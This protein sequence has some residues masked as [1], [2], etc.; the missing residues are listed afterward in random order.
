MSFPR[1]PTYMGSGIEWLGD[2]PVHWKVLPIRRS[3]QIIGGSTPNS[4]SAA[5]WDGD[6]LWATPAD[7]S[8]RRSLY[9]EDTQRKIS[10]EG[11]ESCGTKL[12]PAGSIRSE[13]HTSEL[14]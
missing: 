14:Q 8:K 13:E 7:L 10:A 6:I 11:L 5:L 3:F 2:V 9:I 1:Y 4:E 12:V